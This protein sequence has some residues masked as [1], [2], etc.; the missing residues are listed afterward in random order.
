MNSKK[1]I[2]GFIGAGY[3]G[4]GMC[5]NLLNN[6]F[7]VNVIA[8]NNRKPI[9]KLVSKGAKELKT[10]QELTYKS[11]LILMCLSNTPTVIEVLN[12]IKPHL[13]TNKKI[14][15]LTTHKHNASIKIFEIFK[16]DEIS[17]IVAPVMGGPVQ[18]EKGILGAIVGC[19]KK[20]F[21]FAKKTLN[22]FCK[23]VFYFGS[24]ENAIKVKLLSNFLALGTTTFV[25]ETIKSAKKL[26]VDLNKF[27]SV[28]KL[29][30][31]N[32]GAL[33]RIA[34]KVLND[35]YTGYVFS[36]N[37]TLKDLNYIY[38]LLNDHENSKEL[39]F[40]T[41]SFYEVAKEKGYGDLLISEL[42]NK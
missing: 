8:H 6:F 31:G 18:S 42:I 25:I 4:Y 19:H 39:A 3:M 30:S 13:N 1:P 7:N 22:Y 38:E 41:K 14:I 2:I 34:D 12:D 20:E 40:I 26:D 28:A 17:Y 10:L 5:L 11:D 32:S 35:D 21:D 27:F 23:E 16:S 24:I 37:N 15:D 33:D 36:V 9:E 29:G